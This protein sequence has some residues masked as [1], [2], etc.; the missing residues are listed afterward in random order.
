LTRVASHLVPNIDDIEEQV[1]LKTEQVW[2]HDMSNLLMERELGAA[3]KS[4]DRWAD[5][6]QAAL[7]EDQVAFEAKRKKIQ[8]L[9]NK[10]RK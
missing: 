5:R 10:S 2:A 4:A 7:A 8:K 9:R 1:N 6:Q 3:Y